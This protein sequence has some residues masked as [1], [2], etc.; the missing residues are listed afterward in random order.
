MA[1][2][3]YEATAIK[4]IS[5]PFTPPASIEVVF[6]FTLVHGP[7]PRMS[8]YGPTDTYRIVKSWRFIP[9][10]DHEIAPEWLTDELVKCTFNK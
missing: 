4:V 1:A 9:N 3:Y 8:S 7:S 5:A 6:G 2:D 10:E